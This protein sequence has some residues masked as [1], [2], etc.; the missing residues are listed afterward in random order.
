MQCLFLLFVFVGYGLTLDN[1]SIDFGREEGACAQFCFNFDFFIQ[2]PRILE[3]QV[4][5]LILWQI[6]LDFFFTIY[7]LHEDSIPSPLTLY[8]MD[9]KSTPAYSLDLHFLGTIMQLSVL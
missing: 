8:A 1:Y 6:F 5:S 4:T 7:I 2:Q 9:A 3:K